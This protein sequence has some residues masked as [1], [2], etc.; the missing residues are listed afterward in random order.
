MR[1]RRQISQL[2]GSYVVDVMEYD[3]DIESFLKSQGAV[4]VQDMVRL[5]NLHNTFDTVAFP[6][7]K[8]VRF[9]SI[10][11]DAPGARIFFATLDQALVFSVAYGH[12]ITKSYI[13]E[14]QTLIDNHA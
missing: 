10:L 6:G 11:S 1:D 9:N 3:C 4:S 8:P 14:I 13:K 2:V 12:K 5:D 7:C